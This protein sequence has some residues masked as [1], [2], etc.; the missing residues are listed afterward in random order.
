MWPF[1][2]GLAFYLKIE[3]Y[4]IYSFSGREQSD[5]VIHTKICVCVYIY[6]SNSFPL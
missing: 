2:S 5:S 6:I 4:L 3:I 1:I